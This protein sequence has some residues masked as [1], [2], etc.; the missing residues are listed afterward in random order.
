M[1]RDGI[2]R[3][4]SDGVLVVEAKGLTRLDA[5]GRVIWVNLEL[6]SAGV[7]LGPIVGDAIL[8]RGRFADSEGWRAFAVSLATGEKIE[9]NGP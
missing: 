4:L 6:A 9:W 3:S 2:Q 1:A 8:G 7:E 5:R